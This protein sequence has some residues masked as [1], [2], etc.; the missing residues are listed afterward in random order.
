[1]Y[2]NLKK[3]KFS[4]VYMLHMQLNLRKQKKKTTHNEVLIIYLYTSKNYLIIHLV[5]MLQ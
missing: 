4:L 1:M 3:N 2:V 5:N